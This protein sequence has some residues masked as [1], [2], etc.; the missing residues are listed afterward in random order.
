MSMR[1]PGG[2]RR[3]MHPMEFSVRHPDLEDHAGIILEHIVSNRLVH[4]AS[5]RPLSSRYRRSGSAKG[6]HQPHP[7]SRWRPRR[8]HRFAS[9]GRPDLVHRLVRHRLATS[10]R[11]AGGSSSACLRAGRKERHRRARRRDVDPLPRRGSS[12]RRS[13]LRQRC[14]AASRVMPTKASRRKSSQARREGQEAPPR[15]RAR[16]VGPTSDP[17]CP[18]RSSSASF[19]HP[20]RR[21]GGATVAAGGHVSTEGALGKASSTSPPSRR[22]KAEPCAWLRKRSSAR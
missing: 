11:S 21:E 15:Q 1:H 9:R 4:P 5:R 14:T 8:S 7:G 16:G 19:V 2:C 17:L 18:R 6:R 13:G 3:A 10:A 20:D 22:R 12:G